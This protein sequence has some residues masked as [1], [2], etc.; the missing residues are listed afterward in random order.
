MIGYKIL[1]GSELRMR[2]TP[3]GKVMELSG[4]DKVLD[5][6]I[7]ELNIPE[8]PQRD[9]TI[10]GIRGQFG[11]NALR[12]SIEQMTIIYPDD[13]VTTGQS[14]NIS[15]E[16]NFGLPMRVESVCTLL[17]REDSIADI[18]LV[19]TIGS[20][21]NSE[22][23]DMGM[24]T[25]RYDIEGSQKGLINLDEESGLPVK[26]DIGQKFTGTVSVSGAND[27]EE[28]NW[29]ISGDGRVVITFKKR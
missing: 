14:W 25:L 26:S 15:Y 19:S 24:F 6:I 18:D 28:D 9:K 4:F 1:V 23:I 8:S 2:L 22:D 10:E 13:P 29:P 20:N 5:R 7:E 21:P 16:M 17:S 27:L 12:Q 11:E 3:A